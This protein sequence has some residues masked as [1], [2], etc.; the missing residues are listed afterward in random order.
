MMTLEQDEYVIP[1]LTRVS[2]NARQEFGPMLAPLQAQLQEIELLPVDTAEDMG[3]ANELLRAVVQEKDRIK[4]KLDSWV[5][6][7]QGVIDGLR[8]EARPLL[9]FSTRA[10]A[11]LKGKI[12]TFTRAEL[13][14]K[15]A[16]E[17]MAREAAANRDHQG[18]ALAVNVASAASTAPPQGTSIRYQWKA[19]ITNVYMIP[20]EFLLAERVQ[21]ALLVDLNAHAR[22]AKHP[23]KPEPIPGVLFDEAPIVSVRR[24]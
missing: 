9:D 19:R 10:E 18:A 2:N 20:K 6:P 1:A 4:A 7:L 23:A 5:Q 11:A 16:A 3:F 15:Q 24:G 22:K 21:E 17:A 13:E 12:A 8:A 14:R